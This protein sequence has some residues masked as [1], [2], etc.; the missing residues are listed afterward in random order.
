MSEYI[1]DADQRRAFLTGFNGSNGTAVVTQTKALLWTDG[2]YWTQA[3]NQMSPEWTLMKS[4][5]VVSTEDWLGEH[6][7]R[8]QVVGLDPNF[9]SAAEAISLKQRLSINGIEMRSTV[10]LIDGVWGEDRP[11]FSV[12]ELAIHPESLSGCSV[13]EKLKLLRRDIETNKAQGWVGCALDEICWLFNL[14]GS[15]IPFNPVF[16]AFAVL[17]SNEMHLFTDQ[18]RITKEIQYHIGPQVQVHSY[19]DIGPY[20]AANKA[21][22]LLVDPNQLNYRLYSLIQSKEIMDSPSIVSLHKAKKNNAELD[23]IRQAHLVD[24]VALTAFL[25]WLTTNVGKTTEFEASEKLEEFRSAMPGHKGPSFDTIA[26]YG[27]N[28][29]IIHYK[30]EKETCLEI[31]TDSLFLLDSGGQYCNGTTDVTRTVSFADIPSPQLKYFYTLVLKGHIA[32][33]QLV[34]PEG[35]FGSRLD[36]IA[37]VALWRN[38]LDYPHGTGHGVGAYLNVHEG[39]QGVGF[40]KRNNEVGFFPG[41]TISNEPGYYLEGQ[42]G[43][44]IESVLICK[45][46]ETKFEPDKHFCGFETVTMTP[47]STKLVDVSLL[48]DDELNWLNNY[49]TKVRHSLMQGIMKYFPDSKSYLETETAG[50]TR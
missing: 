15:D 11:V 12:G 34:F 39:P 20:L 47:I 36:S 43:I 1:A 35:T 17:T 32:F 42:F 16:R 46:V 9:V 22:K 18:S 14:R 25:H 41:M 33:E 31:G 4:G 24:G 7:A 23:G 27:H 2:R 19:E 40:R 30:P 44:R 13:A 6:F 26:G 8:G 48:D 50:L 21:N 10:G 45:R 38:G 5:E 49:N 29:A 3:T 37:R 28:G